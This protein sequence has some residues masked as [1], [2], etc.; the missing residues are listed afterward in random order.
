[1]IIAYGNKF[2]SSVDCLSS[3]EAD[4]VWGTISLIAQGNNDLPGLHIETIHAAPPNF[5]SCRVTRD[6]RIIL[7]KLGD[8]VVLLHAA[9]HNDAY[10]WARRTRCEIN[11]ETHVPQFYHVE[12]VAARPARPPAQP[13]AS[14]N[15]Y[16]QAGDRPYPFRNWPADS[17]LLALGVPQEQL[18][19]V[20]GIANAD[21]LISLA[22]RSLLPNSV[23]E[24]LVTLLDEPPALTK[25]L[26]D[27][28][29]E[30]SRLAELGPD[31]SVAQIVAA[32][33][34]ARASIF[35]SGDDVLNAQRAGALDAWRVFLLPEQRKISERKFNGPVY[36][37]GGAGTGKTVVALHRVKWLLEHV[38]TEPDQRILLASFSRTLANTLRSLLSQICSPEQL[39]RVDVTTVDAAATGFLARNGQAVSVDYEGEVNNTRQW[40][41]AALRNSPEVQFD[42]AFLLEEYEDVV[43][44]ND[45]GDEEAYLR[46]SR[47]GRRKT[48]SRSERS[49]I[50]K[51]FEHF[52]RLAS[53][54]S[55]LRKN[56]ALNRAIRLLRNGTPSPYA[57][58]VVDEAQDL[59]A[60]SLRL[61]AAFTG[62]TYAEPRPNSLLLVGDAN[63]RIFGR[64][65]KLSKCGINVVGRSKTL[66]MNYR[67][68]ERIRRRAESVLRGVSVAELDD[69]SANSRRGISA[70][71]GEA[72]EETRAP[73]PEALPELIAS[74]LKR[75]KDLDGADRQWGDYAVLASKKDDA[76]NLAHN[77]GPQGI[78]AVFVDNATDRLDRGKVQVLTM[79][80]AKGLEFVGVAI[81]LQAGKWPAL[82]RNFGRLSQLER[83]AIL[84][85][86]KSLLYVAM[87]RAISR[88]LLTGSGPA[89]SELPRP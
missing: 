45:I 73:S 23:W 20:R 76:K 74:T 24:T 37:S 84:V 49:A 79:H 55:G 51:V 40:M 19:V 75:W 50:W 87:T 11:P 66:R 6:V 32:S 65:V 7:A 21:D 35:L 13:V 67:C 88:L 82:P 43:E 26:E 47:A 34:D 57:A 8:T 58:A 48:L 80:R 52:R 42:R 78:P 27:A 9:H 69:S 14:D 28:K 46:V 71:L 38:C 54:A 15:A 29:A 30:S 68:T 25:L 10:A 85:Q 62:N 56:E 17:S 12:E 3:Q 86:A 22:E 39:R 1:M 31:A 60:P 16:P 72:P 18:P 64:P 70:V 81:V 77:L 63:Q 41:D 83:D 5:R 4:S 53:S 61:L 89:P 2:Q 33:D 59:S 36:V 44:A